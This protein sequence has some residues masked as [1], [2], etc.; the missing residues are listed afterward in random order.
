MSKTS[1]DR[2]RGPTGK[3]DQA[4]R[5]RPGRSKNCNV[6]FLLFFLANLSTANG[7]LAAGEEWPLPYPAT[8]AP[9]HRGESL[10]LDMGEAAV[11][12]R[13]SLYHF[14]QT[15]DALVGDPDRFSLPQGLP[16]RVAASMGTAPPVTLVKPGQAATEQFT[17]DFHTIRDRLVSAMAT[18]PD[19]ERT[20]RQLDYA[21]FLIGRMMLPEARSAVSQVLDQ[22]SLDPSNRD[23][24][25][26][27]RQ[28]IA[29]LASGKTSDLP[30]AWINDP[31]WPVLVAGRPVGQAK[32]RAATAALSTQSRPVATTALPFLF[33]TALASGDATTA[34]EILAAAPAGTDLDATRTL[35]LMRGRLALAQGAE[36][37]AFEAFARL[38]EGDDQAAAEARIAMADMA[39]SRN[40]PS[41]LPQVRHLLQ[42]GMPRW[43]GDATALRLRVRLARVAEDMG[44]IPTAIEVMSAI[45]REHPDT[46]EAGLAEDRIG[47]MIDRLTAAI[48]DSSM[49]LADALA[50]V[51]WLDPAM[52]ER[53]GWVAARAA[54]AQR[55]EAANLAEA[56]K[57][58]YAA[59]AQMPFG[60]LQRAD[61][62]VVDRLTVRHAALLLDSGKSGAALSVLDRRTYPRGPE[63]L[64]HHTS[65]R[66]A[67]GQTAILPGLLL[68]ALKVDD[69]A[70]VASPDVQLALADVA[71]F[72][73][74]EDAALAAFDRGLAAATEPQRLTASRLAAEAGDADRVDRFGKTFEEERAPLQQSVI[75]SLAAP[76]LSGKRL[77]VSGALTLIEAAR[78]A[79]ASVDALL[80]QG[81]AP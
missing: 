54:L 14:S 74:Q 30:A 64:D 81:A 11:T 2:P 46:P 28:I 61:P 12:K 51:R 6:L 55:L 17:G 65:L 70:K 10:R 43:R 21:Q 31:L 25:Q 9:L 56:A 42:E 15:W 80:S 19:A 39:L 59:I 5:L 71:V 24:A 57:A 4:I 8:L 53:C 44:D 69:V 37:M 68:S 62:A 32:L 63:E 45:H 79:G 50:S 76:R 52:A 23:R 18:A 20:A 41:L 48:S 13:A 75:Q 3:P 34:A 33:D 7:A 1:T 73:G 26:G 60:A 40:D 77:S 27:Y 47:V 36:D 49:P 58:E 22:T 29:R 16:R 78:T 35:E 72:A 67:A 66:L 38:A